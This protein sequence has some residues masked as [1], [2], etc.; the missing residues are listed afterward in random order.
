M[1]DVSAQMREAD[2]SVE[3]RTELPLLRRALICLG[4]AYKGTLMAPLSPPPIA[5]YLALPR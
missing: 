3:V 1:L 5:W 2:H 4:R